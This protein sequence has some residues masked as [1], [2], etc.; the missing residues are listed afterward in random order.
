MFEWCRRWRW[1]RR[2][3]RLRRGERER[4]DDADDVVWPDV[5][6]VAEIDHVAIGGKWY[7]GEPEAKK[8]P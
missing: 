7:G 6:K 5:P 4:A 2:T 8:T 3:R 1:R